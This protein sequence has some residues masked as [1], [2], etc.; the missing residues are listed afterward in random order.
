[1]NCAF[2]I[3]VLRWIGSEPIAEFVLNYQRHALTFSSAFMSRKDLVIRCKHLSKLI[4]IGEVLNLLLVFCLI[5]LRAMLLVLHSAC[6]TKLACWMVGR[7]CELVVRWYGI[8]IPELLLFLS[9]V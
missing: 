7:M 4:R 8:I 9:L 3:F 2:R 5:S 6:L 1:M